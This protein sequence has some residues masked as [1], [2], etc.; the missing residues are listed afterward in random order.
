[1][2]NETIEELVKAHIELTV[3]PEALAL[4]KGLRS[5]NPLRIRLPTEGRVVVAEDVSD[6]HNPEGAHPEDQSK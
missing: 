5:M 4:A 1:M 6:L 3:T 2:Q